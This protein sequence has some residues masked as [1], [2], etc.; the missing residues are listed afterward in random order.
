MIRYIFNAYFEQFSLSSPDV[1]KNKGVAET[2]PLSDRL[3]PGYEEL[4]ITLG[5]VSTIRTNN[6]NDEEH[7]SL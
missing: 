6:I 4:N 1:N 2:A 3:K 5:I 7:D